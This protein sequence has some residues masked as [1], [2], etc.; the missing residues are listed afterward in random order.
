MFHPVPPEPAT[1]TSVPGSS[2]AKRTRLPGLEEEVE[3][4]PLVD[5]RGGTSVEHDGVGAEEGSPIAPGSPSASWPRSVSK[6]SRGLFPAIV[7]CRGSRISA[8]EP[9]V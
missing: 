8:L 6:T 3:E 5:R 2:M 9:S 4:P 1:L 7:T